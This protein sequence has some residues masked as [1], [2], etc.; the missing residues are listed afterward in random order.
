MTKYYTSEENSATWIIEKI[1]YNQSDDENKA[2]YIY[3]V[4]WLGDC[5]GSFSDSLTW[6]PWIETINEAMEAHGYTETNPNGETEREM[7]VV[8]RETAKEIF[9]KGG[10]LYTEEGKRLP[11]VSEYSSGAPAESLFYRTTANYD[12]ELYAEA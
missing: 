1:E 4:N 10:Q 2:S 5:A 7:V 11:R 6:Y 8:T 12:G 9:I 3:M